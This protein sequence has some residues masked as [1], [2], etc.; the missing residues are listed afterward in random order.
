M[1]SARGTKSWFDA[2]GW[3]LFW[4]VVI[5]TVKSFKLWRLFTRDIQFAIFQLGGLFIVMWAAMSYITPLHSS[6]PKDLLLSIAFFAIFSWFGVSMLCGKH[7]WKV[8]VRK[9][10]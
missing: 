2:A 5:E 8:F 4:A 10:K 9:K 6:V 7:V 3:G 1:T